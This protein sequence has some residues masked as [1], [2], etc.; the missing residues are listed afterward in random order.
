MDLVG[1]QESIVVTGYRNHIAQKILEETQQIS[2]RRIELILFPVKHD[3]AVCQS[4]SAILP[5]RSSKLRHTLRDVVNHHI[6]IEAL[7][8]HCRS[9][10]MCHVP[11]V[12]SH[13]DVINVFN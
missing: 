12:Q 6:H 4:A 8:V 5:N 11:C 1:R 10:W 7:I 3:E 13:V 2:R 9:I